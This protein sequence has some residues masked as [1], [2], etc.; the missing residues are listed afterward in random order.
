MVKSVNS[1]PC[2]PDSH[3]RNWALIIIVFMICLTCLLIKFLPPFIEKIVRE[4]PGE[5]FLP[6]FSTYI[7][8][9]GTIGVFQLFSQGINKLLKD[10]K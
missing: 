3:S 4:T 10:G 5:S 7:A 9:L 6:L 2:N 1:Q 8:G